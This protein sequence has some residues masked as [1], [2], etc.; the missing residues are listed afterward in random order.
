MNLFFSTVARE[1]ND[2]AKKELQNS[3]KKERKYWNEF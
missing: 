2:Y 1:I 3:G